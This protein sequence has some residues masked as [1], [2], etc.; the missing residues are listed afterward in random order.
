M[1]LVAPAALEQPGS[2]PP[3]ATAVAASAG[4]GNEDSDAVGIIGV[5]LGALA[6]L[7]AVAAFI[8]GR[9][10]STA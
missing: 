7:V 2:A 9:R 10:A 8:R 3:S 1:S 6:Q 4:A 5:V